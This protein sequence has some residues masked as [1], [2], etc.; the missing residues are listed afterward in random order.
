MNTSLFTLHNF[1]VIHF[2]VAR[3]PHLLVAKSLY[4]KRVACENQSVWKN[5]L[6]LV[7]AIPGTARP[8]ATRHRLRNDF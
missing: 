3:A 1:G 8:D 6:S 4:P 2:A 7:R 5:N